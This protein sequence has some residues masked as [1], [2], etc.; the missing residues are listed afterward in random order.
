MPLTASTL[1]Q[2]RGR[3]AS[4]C[5]CWEGLWI[6]PPFLVQ[7]GAI[8]STSLVLTVNWRVVTGVF[9]GLALVVLAALGGLYFFQVRGPL[10]WEGGLLRPC[11]L[12][13]ANEG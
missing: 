10:Q 5:S 6:F 12:Q 2:V 1:I 9:V 8:R 4:C 7:L 13:G 11:L 3:R